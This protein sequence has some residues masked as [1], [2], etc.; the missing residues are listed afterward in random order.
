MLH[1]A[2]VAHLPNSTVNAVKTDAA[3]N[4]YI[5][6]S[7][8]PQ[9]TSHAFVAKLSPTGTVVYSTTFAGSKVDTAAAID[10]D[11]AG[12]AY[13]LGQTT[14]PDFPVTPGALQ[15][16]LQAANGQ[17]FVA[18]VDP[19]GKVVYSTFIGGSASIGPIANGLVVDSA[20]DAIVS[21]S[22]IGGVFPP[23]PGAPFTSTD[24]NTV[25]VMKL[26]PTGAKMLAAVHGLGGHLALDAQGSVYIAGLQ[27]G[28]NTSIPVTAGALQS[29]FRLQG[30]GGDAQVGIGCSYQYVAKL[31]AGLTQIVYATYVAGSFGAS[32]VAISV[33][34]QGDA[35][36]AGTTNSPDYPT[37][38]NAYEPVYI[39]NAPYPPETCLFFCI[40]PPP[41]A[42]YLTE[43]NPTGTGLVYSTF[44]SGTQQDTVTF[45]AFT[46]NGIYLSGSAGSADLPGLEGY[47]PQCL[48]QTYATRLSADA[49]EV[50]AIRLP[51]GNIL[52]Y[53]AAAGSLLA[54]T[55]SDLVTFDL[56]APLPPISCIVDALDMKPVTAIAPG[57]LLTMFGQRF[58]GGTAIPPAGQFPTSLG[59]VTISINGIASPLLYVSP[60]QINVQAP[61]EI[62]GA[63]QANI[64]LKAA[65]SD[66]RTLQLVASN[67]VAFLDTATPLASLDS[68]HLNGGAYNGGPLPLAFNADGSRN[69]CT[70]P[71][72]K[73]S[74]VTLYLDGLG[75]VS[76]PQVTGAITPSPGTPLTLPITASNGAPFT[77]VAAFAVPGLISGVWEVQIRP[78]PNDIGAIPIYL[79]VGGVAVRDGDLTIWVQ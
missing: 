60:Q 2:T 61:F 26:D 44:F 37:T 43:L 74:V 51:P 71:A 65:V 9:A 42:G 29:T 54:W 63:A 79:S 8:G 40:F 59:G 31:N 68:C 17:G 20:G 16:T 49:T 4:I 38:A 52:A 27:Y 76:P 24:I 55:G 3:G 47:P 50:G 32:P 19:T 57:E 39:A 33:D 35:F 45:A 1:A 7:Q 15:T 56:T 21:G 77:E 34:A 11:S 53:D 70:N 58:A 41:A 5:A 62:A 73:G 23:T 30:C 48:P 13:I 64:V 75:V 22:T 18:K 67:P 69:A 25:F 6:G 46:A 28:G 72:A 66:S 12:A 78:A 36:V 10:I 14:S